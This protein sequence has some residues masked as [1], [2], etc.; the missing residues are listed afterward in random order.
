MQQ[1]AS[2]KTSGRTTD[3]QLHLQMKTNV[4]TP[5]STKSTWSLSNSKLQLQQQTMLSIHWHHRQHQ[6]SHDNQH[7]ASAPATPRHRSRSQH[8]KT[9]TTP[10]STPQQLHV[11]QQVNQ[12]R[13]DTTQLLTSNIRITGSTTGHTIRLPS[14]TFR[15]YKTRKVTNTNKQK[16]Q[17]K[18]NRYKQST[19]SCSTATADHK[20]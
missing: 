7:Q 5:W 12:Q 18:I 4:N 17:S 6:S 11:H 13:Q 1:Q 8:V 9:Q 15:T 16:D 14:T 3:Q 2:D 10:Q 19:S 20:H